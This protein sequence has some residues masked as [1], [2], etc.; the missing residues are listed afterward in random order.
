MIGS[1]KFKVVAI[2]CIVSSSVFGQTDLKNSISVS[3]FGEMI[4]HPGFRIGIE[5]PVGK[6]GKEKK[7]LVM[8]TPSAGFFHHKRYQTSYFI[9]PDIALQLKGK[10]SLSFSAGLG[11][12]TQVSSVP[13]TYF[14]T[15]DS[16][17]VK[18]SASRWY[19]LGNFFVEAEKSFASSE[20]DLRIFLKPQILMAYPG[21]PKRT[22]YFILEFGL[23]YKIPK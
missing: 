21:F 6:W 14:V 9:L 10:K 3:Y 13:D 8:V 15:K 18:I 19:F 22:S 23:K 7:N 5:T 1:M 11:V 2:L 17:V 16:S 20:R 4:T 12:G